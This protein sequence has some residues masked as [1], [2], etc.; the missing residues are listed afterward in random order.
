MKVADFKAA[1][2]LIPELQTKLDHALPQ[3]QILVRKLEQGPPFNAPLEVRLYGPN[4]DRLKSIGED[5][6][7]IMAETPDVTHTR[8]TLQPGTPK[9]W[10]NVNEEASQLSG[11]SLSELADLLHASLTG[12]VSGNVIEATES[13]PVR[14]R[15]K[16]ENRENMAN[17]SSLR[18]PVRSSEGLTGLP[19]F[20]LADLEL[21][22]SRGAIPRR[23]GQRVNVIEAIS[24][25]VCYRK[26][27][28]TTSSKIWKFMPRQ[29]L[30]ATQLNSAVN[31]R[32]EMNQSG[33]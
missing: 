33:T 23:N 2:T 18:L 20:A 12:R 21:T 1:N 31:R 29:S 17:L 10:I 13:I 5:I 8:E 4:L 6:R 28:S 27:L 14:V 26:P 19:V 9:V 15:V 32:N 30:P 25:P 16:D 24:E 22:P 7:L 11:L 3:A